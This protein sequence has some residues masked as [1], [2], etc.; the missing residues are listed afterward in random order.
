M[1]KKF[2]EEELLE[3]AE[4]GLFNLSCEELKEIIKNESKK[5]YENIN[6]NLIDLCFDILAAK[7]NYDDALPAKKA[8]HKK[9][10]MRNIIAV[11]TFIVI[12]AVVTTVS[13]QYFNFNIPKEISSWIEGNAKT[14]INLKL[15]D[16]TAD[17]YSL[18]DSDLANE[19]EAQGVSPITF[20]E[21]LI[22][23]HSNIIKIDNITT[24]ETI[25]TDV[26]IEFNYNNTFGALAVSQYKDNFEWNGEMVT[27][28]VLSAE[29]I[30]VNGMDVLIFESADSC[31]I[32]YRDH[33]TTYEIYLETDFETARLFAQSIK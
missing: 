21:E 27:N 12:I 3:T 28:D 9:I 16:T 19:L 14:E 31:T 30:E 13:A 6:T 23:E 24:V 26:E 5:E 22:K 33:L 10:K 1:N 29:I 18:K 7:E 11:A 25:S 2:S 32:R 8:T 4:S 20:P 15:A 17:V